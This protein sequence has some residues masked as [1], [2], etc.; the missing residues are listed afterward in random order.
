MRL[1]CVM[2]DGKPHWQCLQQSN[3]IDFALAKRVSCGAQRQ[4]E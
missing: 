1:M 3:L 2:V 4:W